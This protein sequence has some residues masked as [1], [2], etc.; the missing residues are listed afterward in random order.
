MAAKSP[1]N[2]S[3][4]NNPNP[5]VGSPPVIGTD[6]GPGNQVVVNTDGLVEAGKK[7]TIPGQTIEAAFKKW[8]SGLSPLGEPWGGPDDEVGKQFGPNYR[9]NEAATAEV[10]TALYAGM[11]AL[12]GNFN[13]MT[14]NFTNAEE[15]NSR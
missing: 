4:P 3:S 14:K 7:C 2:S 15:H 8:R 9:K 13:V 11:F 10:L 6:S 1:S 12:E 5:T